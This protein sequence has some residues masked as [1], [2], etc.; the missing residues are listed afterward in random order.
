M[1]TLNFMLSLGM[2][3]LVNTHTG[4]TAHNVHTHTKMQCLHS[5]ASEL[6]PR[7][8]QLCLDSA[9]F[10]IFD[11]RKKLIKNVQPYFTMQNVKT[12]NNNDG[13]L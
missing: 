2:Y 9:I 5:I 4:D 11:Q 7:K 1:S 6:M 3:R 13:S 8:T 10:L 12:H